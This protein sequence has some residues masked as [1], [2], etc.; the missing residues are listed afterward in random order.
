MPSY[1]GKSSVLLAG[2][3]SKTGTDKFPSDTSATSALAA[4]QASASDDD[5]FVERAT[6]L[7]QPCNR[8]AF[9]FSVPADNSE[10]SESTASEINKL[11][12][13][14]SF[15]RKPRHSRYSIQDVQ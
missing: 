3:V 14:F 7:T 11:P 2:Q 6:A 5:L 8:I 1:N 10:S 9:V 13:F 15:T 4:F 12:H